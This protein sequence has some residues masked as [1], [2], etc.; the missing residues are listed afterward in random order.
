MNEFKTESHSEE[1]E[2]IFNQESV[3]FEEEMKFCY[4]KRFESIFKAYKKK[5]FSNY[6]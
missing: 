5:S 4:S 6:P 1:L 3:S 2:F